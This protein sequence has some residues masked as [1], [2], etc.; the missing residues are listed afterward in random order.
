[1]TVDWNASLCSTCSMYLTTLGNAPMSMRKNSWPYLMYDATATSA[2]ESSEPRSQGQ[3]P[4]E[5]YCKVL[6]IL[7][8]WKKNYIT[9]YKHQV[10][11]KMMFR[12]NKK[13]LVN[14]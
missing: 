4:K 5:K 11:M 8:K 10:L 1:M 13:L 14:S 3:R 6:T 2:T 7:K 9:N 12:N